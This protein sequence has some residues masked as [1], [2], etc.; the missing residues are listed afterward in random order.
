MKLK[1]KKDNN[2]KEVNTEKLEQQ[3]LKDIQN[4]NFEISKLIEKK[5]EI[6]HQILSLRIKPFEIGGYALVEI[7]SGRSKKWQKCLLECEHGMLYVRPVKEDGSL[8]GR[9]F[10]IIS[11]DYTDL[12]KEVN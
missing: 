10:S 9:H 8:S 5:R 12:L 1:T 6:E 2:V 11:N 7:T 3:L 4:I